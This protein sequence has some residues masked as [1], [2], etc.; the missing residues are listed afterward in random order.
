MDRMTPEITVQQLAEKLK[1][2]DGFILLDVREAWELALA[3]IPDDR[4]IVQPMSEL[5][6]RGLEALPEA[7]R[8]KDAEIL[9]MCHH[10]VRSADVTRWLASH[11]WTNV[12]SVAGGIDEY[13]RVIE[14]GVG[15]Y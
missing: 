1:S 11:G 13:A 3:K 12:W 5:A 10:G 8:Q 9:V 15:V 7:A 6:S 14:P 4:L 2:P